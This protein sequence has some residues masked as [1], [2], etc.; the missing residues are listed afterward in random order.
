MR[1]QVIFHE[2]RK[3]YHGEARLTKHLW[4]WY[5]GTARKTWAWIVTSTG[6]RTHRAANRWLR[7]AACVKKGRWGCKLGIP[8]GNRADLPHR[9]CN[10][11][12]R[13]VG[14]M[15]L[16]SGRR[17]GSHVRCGVLR[18][19]CGCNTN[20]IVQ[21]DQIWHA[22][23][24]VHVGRGRRGRVIGYWRRNRMLV[25][26]GGVARRWWFHHLNITGTTGWTV[27]RRIALGR[28]LL[29]CNWWTRQLIRPFLLLQRLLPHFLTH[30]FQFFAD[31]FWSDTRISC[32]TIKAS[33]KNV[34][35]VSTSF[36]AYTCKQLPR[37]LRC[38]PFLAL[39]FIFRLVE[40]C[41]GLQFPVFGR[42][43]F[44]RLKLHYTT[45]WLTKTQQIIHKN[46]LWYCTRKSN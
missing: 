11:W 37:N 15:S 23:G 16:R 13:V 43:Q 1:K 36:D 24:V 29:W 41:L 5:V 9:L 30:L 46:L 19:H 20:W 7:R 39:A 34:S 26:M 17:Y 10:I 40:V 4:A 6:N 2:N 31:G 3:H 18:L 22:F 25:C 28:S 32:V 8:W 44:S 12:L 35:S 21:V 14:Y 42:R 27:I 45:R 33:E 38:V